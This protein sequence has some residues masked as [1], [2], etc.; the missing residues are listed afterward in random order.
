M[1]TVQNY[2]HYTKR[3]LKLR[4]DLQRE[5]RILADDIKRRGWQ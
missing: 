1:I 4:Q 5:S 3:R 2:W